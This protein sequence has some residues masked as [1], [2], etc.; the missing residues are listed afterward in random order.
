MFE[1]YDDKF[2]YFTKSKNE[3]SQISK[4]VLNNIYVFYKHA[5]NKKNMMQYLL[6]GLNNN[7]LKFS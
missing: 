4:E 2:I 7:T 5:E 1:K 3:N 6:D